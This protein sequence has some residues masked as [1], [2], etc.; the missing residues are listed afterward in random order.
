MAGK[1]GR[2]MSIDSE[3]MAVRMPSRMSSGTPRGRVSI[4]RAGDVGRSSRAEDTR[5]SGTTAQ[6]A[7]AASG[8]LWPIS[9]RSVESG[10]PSRPGTS[11]E[12]VPRMSATVPLPRPP[13]AHSAKEAGLYYASDADPGITRVK[14]GRAFGYRGVDGRPVR[15]RATLERIRSLVI[16]PAWQK[17]WIA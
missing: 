1:A 6:G 7:L 11:V 8:R 17:V 10:T 3:A 4:D 13:G 14:I 12:G 16:P 15:D 9:P 2:Y 5:A